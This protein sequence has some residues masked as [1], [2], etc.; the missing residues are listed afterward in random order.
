MKIIQNALALIKVTLP[1]KVLP[2][3][4]KGK[5]LEKIS[6]ELIPAFLVVLVIGFA[7]QGRKH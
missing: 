1:N 4:I 2:S 3:I 6:Q 5:T 7:K